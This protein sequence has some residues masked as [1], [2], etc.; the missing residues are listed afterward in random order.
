MKTT[1][2]TLALMSL[3]AAGCANSKEEQRRAEAHQYKSDQAAENGQYELA[4]DEQRKAADSHH[5]AVKKAINEGSEIPRQTEKG[6]P[7]PDGG[8]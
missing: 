8:S 2:I 6:D 7:N 5:K 1:L 3:A 4:G